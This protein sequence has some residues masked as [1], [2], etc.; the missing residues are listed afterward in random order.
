MPLRRFS[1]RT[2]LLLAVLGAASVVAA[3]SGDDGSVTSPAD[4]GTDAQEPGRTDG[5]AE[6]T[7]DC[8]NLDCDDGNA[9]TVDT[10][11]ANKGCSH[12]ARNGSMTFDPPVADF[13]TTNGAVTPQPFKALQSGV[14]VTQC[15]DWSLDDASIGTLNGS[16]FTPN[17]TFGGKAT[18]SAKLG[19]TTSTLPITVTA[20]VQSNSGNLT[21]GDRT[22]LDTPSATP[23]P[24][25]DVTYP[26]D[27]TVFP[28][29]VLS[30]L[31]QWNGGQANDLYRIQV[32]SRYFEAVDYV[33]AAPS[34]L[35]ELADVVWQAL[36]RSGQ[37]AE[38]DPATVTL[39]RSSANVTYA[40][41][42][43]TWHV[44][45]GRL[46]GSVYYRELPGLGGGAPNGRLA[47][48]R[49]D[50]GSATTV[51]GGGACNSCH[52]VSRNGRHLLSSFDSGP[53]F[54][55]RLTDLTQ[56]PPTTGPAGLG[57]NVKG[58]F[59][60]FN[61]AGDKALV[62]FDAANGTFSLSIVNL[63]NGQSVASDVLGSKCAEPSWSPDGSR[64]A[65]ICGLQGG[66]WAFD[67]TG[68]SLRIGTVNADGVTIDS[69]TDLVL[70]NAGQGRPSYPKFS[71]DSAFIAYSRTTTGSR[72]TGNGQ[73]WLVAVDGSFNKQLTTIS[74][75]NHEYY[76]SFAPRRAGGY[77]WLAF[78]SKRSYGNT[79]IDKPQI[80]VAAIKD[81]PNETDPSRPAF[82]L[83]GQVASTMAYETDFAA[84]V[85]VDDGATCSS[86]TDC[87]GGTCVVTTPG[88]T[89]T[90]GAQPAG[91]C[92]AESN[93]C[94]KSSDCC[95]S[96]QACIDKVCQ[97]TAL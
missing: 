76:P 56:A 63:S 41:A 80:W 4:A 9:C 48:L 29:D 34:S 71:P 45:Q 6:P 44:A 66:G 13:V 62:S 68:G 50:T 74:R 38:S 27:H 19:T 22:A 83:R 37:G 53:P 95:G 78:T 67:H 47:V 97:R 87:C 88:S 89:G 52:S 20:I 35:C 86:G 65:A 81:P 36:G 30:P 5:G 28:L 49:P 61:P 10:C 21:D 18:L 82:Y 40:P 26:E 12:E 59:S 24:S 33:S 1:S 3:C 93:R 60:A 90:C 11:D 54:D 85:C 51:T 64:I 46:S 69:S 7:Y 91:A 8:A 92:V 17:G 84:N 75:G 16:V 57:A 14:D 72:S 70:A 96:A 73:L 77:Y 25:L 94:S 32:K 55:L 42:T 2:S 15:V 58:T 79:T 39:T 23:D 31:V 43:R